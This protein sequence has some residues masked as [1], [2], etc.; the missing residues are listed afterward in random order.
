MR[1]YTYYITSFA[2]KHYYNDKYAITIHRRSIRFGVP[3]SLKYWDFSQ[4]KWKSTENNEKSLVPITYEEF[5][6]RPWAP[7]NSVYYPKQ[8]KEE[9]Q[10]HERTK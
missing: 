10:K 4:L 8:F 7:A 3:N 6:K 9:W 2:K 5:I 1:T